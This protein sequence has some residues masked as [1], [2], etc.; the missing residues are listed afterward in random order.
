MNLLGNETWIFVLF[1]IVN[2]N[3]ISTQE[4][5]E[6]LCD[7]AQNCVK[8]A[9]STVSLKCDL[10]RIW[11]KSPDTELGTL[12][13][14]S[15][16]DSEKYEIIGVNMRSMVPAL[17]IKKLDYTDSGHG[18]Y[19]AKPPSFNANRPNCTY[20]IFVYDGISKNYLSSFYFNLCK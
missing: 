4:P 19:F 15:G 18:S 6:E 17:K 20:N 9:M 8:K 12:K 11:F 14:E 5:K 3:F 1:L 16:I 10:L 7:D 2:F 13:L